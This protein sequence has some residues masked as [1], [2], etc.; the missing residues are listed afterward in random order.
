MRKITQTPFVILVW[1]SDLNII[2]G[3]ELRS[4]HY[5]VR[6]WSSREGGMEE[7]L[8]LGILVESAVHDFFILR[9]HVPKNW[10]LGFWVIVIIL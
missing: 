2:L 4:L 3:D 7:A 5:V 10:V 9:V 6:S 8:G 1:V